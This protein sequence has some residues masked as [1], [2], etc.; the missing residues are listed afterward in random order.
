M[1]E[2]EKPAWKEIVQYF[3]EEILLKDKTLNRKRLGEIVFSNMDKRKR[4]EGFTHPR[5]FNECNLLI[6]QYSAKDPNAIIEAVVPLMFEVNLAHRFHKILLV[7]IPP[8]L[9]IERLIKRDRI[10]R[11][12]ALNILK[13]Q[14]S[15][16]EKKEYADFIV[17]NS[18]SLDETRTQ[19]EAIWK[20]LKKY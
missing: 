16:E 7:Y 18:G 9:Q 3:G 2:P 14:M 17:D 12:M 20:K 19:V 8:E 5:I 10:S 1:V 6:K 15:I 11:R 4:L 13:A